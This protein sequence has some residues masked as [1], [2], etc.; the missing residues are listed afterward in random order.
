MV[1]NRS[2]SLVS[3]LSFRTAAAS[4][5]ISKKIINKPAL[6]L[7]LMVLCPMKCVRFGKRIY[8]PCHFPGKQQCP[9]QIYDFEYLICG[10]I[11]FE[12]IY[13]QAVCLPVPTNSSYT[14]GSSLEGNAQK[15][16]QQTQGHS[17]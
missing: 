16:P 1:T 12:E 13:S 6:T 9:R 2:T 8:L 14:K 10:G 17:R 15:P 7:L 4:Q 5:N 3:F 11:N